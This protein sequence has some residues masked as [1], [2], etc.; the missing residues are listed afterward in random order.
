MVELADSGVTRFPPVSRH[1]SQVDAILSAFRCVLAGRSAIYASLPIT[2]GKLLSDWHAGDKGLRPGGPTYDEELKLRVLDPNLVD[3]RRFVAALRASSGK[4]VIDPSELGP[5][6]NWTQDDYRF[7]W[8]LVIREFADT[9]VFRD[10]W[11]Y[12]SGCA[13]EFLVASRAGLR[14]LDARLRELPV[15]SA[16]ALIDLAR[17]DHGDVRMSSGFLGAVVGALR[18]IGDDK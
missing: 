15:A 18:E 2:T 17:R 4:P 14:T 9:V 6:A 7:L 8:G 11:Q 3:A 16:M 13:Y 5:I 10:G 1:Q 12:S